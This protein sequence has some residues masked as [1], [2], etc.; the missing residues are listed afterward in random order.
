MPLS[1]SSAWAPYV[2]PPSL[3]RGSHSERYLCGVS[4]DRE[5]HKHLWG[6][7]KVGELVELTGTTAGGGSCWATKRRVVEAP[8]LRG[9]EK[10]GTNCLLV[11]PLLA[12]AESSCS[13]AAES[14]EPTP[15]VPK[16]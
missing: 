13:T 10:A 14:T 5:S 7:E 12:L 9:D 16:G 1:V 6:D 4:L 2:F 3:F 15:V 8:K 11:T